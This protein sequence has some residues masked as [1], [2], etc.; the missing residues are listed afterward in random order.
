L[1]PPLLPLLGGLVLQLLLPHTLWWLAV[2]VAVD[3]VAAVV[4]QAV[5]EQGHCL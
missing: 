1:E 2:V 3:S 5:S 4:A